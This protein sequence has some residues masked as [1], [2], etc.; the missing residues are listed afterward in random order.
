MITTNV[1]ITVIVL[2]IAGLI[3]LAIKTKTGKAML[4]YALL[5][6]ILAFFASCDTASSKTVE[7]EI[8]Y[9]QWSATVL[10]NG[11][12]THVDMNFSEFMLHTDMDSVW[13]DLSTHRIDDNSEATMMCVL[14]KRV[15]FPRSGVERDIHQ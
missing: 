2:L 6:Y 11:T 14:N 9:A 13:V 8:P 10:E 7:K 15:V 5:V 4:I 3:I 1:T 12:T